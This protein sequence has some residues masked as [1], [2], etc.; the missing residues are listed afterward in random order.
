MNFKEGQTV[1]CNLKNYMNEKELT[2][3]QLSKDIDV[4]QNAI[5][6]YMKNR[7]S[8]IDCEI[9]AKLCNYFG[10]SFGEMFELSNEQA[11]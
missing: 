4:T 10:V 9:A 8:R 7:F 11:A 6:A 1:I 2:I 3:T 5:R